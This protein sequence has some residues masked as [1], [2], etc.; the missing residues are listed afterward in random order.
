MPYRQPFTIPEV[1]DPPKICLQIN[2]PGTDD[3]KQVIA[4]LLWELTQWFN[5]ERDNDESGRQLAAVYRDVFLSID[6]SNMSCCPDDVIILRRV[7][8]E[9]PYL[10][11]ISTDGG[12]TWETD[13]NNPSITATQLP[14]PTFDEHHTKCDAASNAL[15]HL[16]D[17]VAKQVDENSSGAVL[18]T[19]CIDIALFIAALL[20]V[21][22]TEGGALPIVT[23][24]LVSVVGA[25]LALSGTSFADYFTSDVWD[26]VL[27]ALYCHIEDDGTFTDEGWANVIIQMST[28]MPAGTPQA[29]WLIQMVKVMGAR[30]LTTLAAYGESADADCGACGCGACDLSNWTEINSQTIT[31]PNDSV[32]EVDGYTLGGG[33]AHYYAGIQAPTNTG[34]S[35]EIAVDLLS[36]SVSRSGDARYWSVDGEGVVTTHSSP[37]F[38]SGT[39]CYRTLYYSSDFPFRLRFTC[40]IDCP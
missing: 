5:W 25:V 10:I 4:G 35:H 17:L 40:Y 7:D 16:K 14:P 37:F 8:P 23:P 6:W 1:I 27:C 26:S 22:F 11:Q 12:V 39:T 9:H 21:V 34:N 38:G 29:D 3:H 36:G 30:G 24:V 15:Q 28:D 33:D 13:P 32:I 20:L 2:I 18:I 19:V 31:R